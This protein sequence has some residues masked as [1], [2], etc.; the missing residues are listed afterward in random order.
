MA[1]IQSCSLVGRAA[2]GVTGSGVAGRPLS[3]LL[4]STPLRPRTLA[5]ESERHKVQLITLPS[6]LG[7]VVCHGVPAWERGT[8]GIFLNH[9]FLCYDMDS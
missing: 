9:F 4:A 1:T 3:S 6:R 5:G 7:N 8:G 2:G